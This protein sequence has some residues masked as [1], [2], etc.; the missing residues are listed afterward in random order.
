M[1]PWPPDPYLAPAVESLA[2]HSLSSRQEKY[3][4]RARQLLVGPS[5]GTA[6]GE[7]AGGAA[8]WD[9]V[10]AGQPLQVD[11]E[12]YKRLAAGELQVRSG[13]EAGGARRSAQ[14]A[15]GSA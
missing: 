9:T 14:P 12:Y 13:G 3:L 8:G 11:V 4:D 15:P 5:A 10:A 6:G 2:R 7:G 1:P